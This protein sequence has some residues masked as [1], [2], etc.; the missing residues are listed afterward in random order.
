MRDLHRADAVGELRHG[1]ERHQ[2]TARGTHVEQ[3]QRR[4]IGLVARR[5][6]QDH[7]VLVGRGIDGRDLARAVGVVERHLDRLRRDAERGGLLALDLHRDLGARDLQVA[8]HVEQAGQR[9]QLLLDERRPVIELVDA[10]AAHDVLVGALGDLAADADRRDV[11]HEHLGAEHIGDLGTQLAHHLVGGPAL[12][13][14][15]QVD[16]DATDVE[17]VGGAAGADERHHRVD[18]RVLAHDLRDLALQRDHR[19]EGNVL[20]SFDEA[21][22]LAGVLRGQEALRRAREQGHRRDADAEEHD[23]HRAAVAERPAQRY[24]ISM[25]HG[26]EAALE[27][28]VQAPVALV[29]EVRLEDAA[30][31][32]RRQRERDEARDQHRGD[33]GDGELV[34]QPPEDAAH[35]QHR[36]EHRGERDGHRDDGEDDLLRALEGRLQRRLA[37]LQ[38]P[39][40][41]LEHH[42]GVVDHEADAQGERHQ[43]NV[44]EAVAQHVHHRE[45]ADDRHRQGDRR[46]DGRRDI[47]QEQENH[48]HHQRE[49]EQQGE[50]H[51]VDRGADGL[52][53]VVEHLDVDRRR[54][55]GAEG[56][57]E[58]AHLVDHLDGVG[59]GL[60]VDREHDA[61]LVLVP[62]GHLVVLHAVDDAAELLQPDRRAVAVGDDDRPEGRGV[63]ELPRGLHRVHAFLAVQRAGGQVDVGLRDGLLDF[64]DADAARGERARID[65]HAHR[66]FLLAEH[67]HL[68]HAGDRGDAL[69]EVGLGV[70]VH[71]RKRQRL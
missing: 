9:A 10:R 2:R 55:L 3:R 8:R 34:E 71:G 66:V 18:V 11:L 30:A 12:A 41:V 35:E 16:G 49:R 61:A 29:L 17:R 58:L 6:L 4:R 36:D 57:Q 27:G 64:V 59:A 44:V 7:E 42:D 33:D 19:V 69:R 5:E 60:A 24:L 51:L 13:E 52:R 26:V 21:Q 31:H 39:R 20:R 38:M 50:L 56:R 67:L 1:V 22:E 32:H 48:H 53:A 47:A 45:G 25:L 54:H 37:H 63:V 62:G 23:H 65:L 14:G 40:D 68:R 43:R 46:D 15:L 70:L 28:H